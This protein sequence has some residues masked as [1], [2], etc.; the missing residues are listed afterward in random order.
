VVETAGVTG[1]EGCAIVGGTRFGVNI[2]ACTRLGGTAVA[3]G[4]GAAPALSG[5]TFGCA[6]ESVS[7]VEADRVSNAA[8]DGKC[9]I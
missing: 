6:T 1:S 5:N 2:A 8:R 3:A 4:G 9:R 7:S